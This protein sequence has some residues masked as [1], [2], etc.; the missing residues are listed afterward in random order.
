LP[1]EK[2]G[3]SPVESFGDMMKEFGE[4]I[5]KI[6][7]DPE[8]KKKSKEFA[9]SAEESAKTFG[10][11]FKD[12]GVKD[13]FKDFKKAAGNFGSSV[14][15]Y[16][17]GDAEKDEEA[18]ES[19]WEKKIDRK[20]EEF[21]EK[22]E[23][24][25]QEFGKK[26]EKL[27]G[28]VDS[29]FKDTRGGRMAGYSFAIMWSAAIFVLFNFYSQYIAYYYNDGIWHRYPML[30]ESFSQWLPIVSVALVAAIIGNIILI[31]Y[32]GYFFYQLIH[33]ILNL[34]GLSAVISLLIIFPF[35]FTVFPGDLT[36]T[37][38]NITIVVLVLIIIGMIVGIIV[39]TVKMIVNIARGR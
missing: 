13:K 11:R 30:T 21:G 22:T 16:F 14:S 8:L 33:I 5:S 24:A 15:E 37:L 38:N 18:R 31:I 2:K 27:G 3:K 12:E 35:N 26:M 10:K 20:M 4:T 25:G 17:K 7:N 36:S 19:G 34:F 29:Y 23:K 32:D 28:K 6:F 1:E 39:R 9:K